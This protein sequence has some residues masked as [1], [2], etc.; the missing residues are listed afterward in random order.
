V[1]GF[2]GKRAGTD[3]PFPLAKADKQVKPDIKT[4]RTR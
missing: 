3:W 2:S 4:R 1:A